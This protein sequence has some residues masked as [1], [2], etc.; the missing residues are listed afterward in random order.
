MNERI[1]VALEEI[2]LELRKLNELG[3]ANSVPAAPNA[4]PQADA[5]PT[6]VGVARRVFEPV[7]DAT[8]RKRKGQA[9]RSV[10]DVVVARIDGKE[11]EGVVLHV[12]VDHRRYFSVLCS[13][14][15]E[16]MVIAR[17][18]RLRDDAFVDD[19]TCVTPPP[20]KHVA[21]RAPT[22]AKG[23]LVEAV[24]PALPLIAVGDRVSYQE[25]GVRLTFEVRHLSIFGASADGRNWVKTANLERE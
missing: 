22:P 11:V 16:K 23:R 15:T 3:V 9:T 13:D 5:A 8:K 6:P 20:A 19:D 12:P 18:L 14:G 2:V 7:E 10:G 4:T 17:N 24:A 1:A 25:N 21:H